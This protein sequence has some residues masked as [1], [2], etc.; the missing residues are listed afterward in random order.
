M[1]IHR[2]SATTYWLGEEV[3]N[4][5]AQI[6]EANCRIAVEIKPSGM[7]KQNTG[8]WMCE[9]WQKAKA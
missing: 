6:Y 9:N 2:A 4:K 1:S 7:P 3:E 5:Y 8:P